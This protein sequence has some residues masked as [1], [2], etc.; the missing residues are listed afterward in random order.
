LIPVRKNLASKDD[1]LK[2]LI[3]VCNTRKPHYFSNFATQRRRT[4]P[5]NEM[6]EVRFILELENI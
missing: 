3:D 2:I 1:V 6:K 4:I 5:L